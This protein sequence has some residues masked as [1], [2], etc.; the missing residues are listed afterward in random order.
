MSLPE[1][2][3]R[4][5]ANIVEKIAADPPERA[6]KLK[7]AGEWKERET[8]APKTI[9]RNSIAIPKKNPSLFRNSKAEFNFKLCWTIL[10]SACA[11][12]R[13]KSLRVFLPTKSDASWYLR[14]SKEYHNLEK[15][16]TFLDKALR[17]KTDFHQWNLSCDQRR[18]LEGSR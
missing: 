4:D 5:A 1:S 11:A 13:K 14:I 18:S 9:R 2:G 12:Y 10:A 15:P 7:K 17:T 6:T 8:S 3:K 16:K